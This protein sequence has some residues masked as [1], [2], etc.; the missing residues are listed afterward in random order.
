MQYC[1]R[2]KVQVLSPS[3]RCPLCQGSLEGEPEKEGQMFPD[4]TRGRSM[5][6]LFWKIFNFFCVAVVV[7]G[8][9][10]NLMIP[11]RI[12]WAGFLAAAVLC[13]WILTAVAIF[14]RKNLLKNALWEMALV[15]G[16]CIFWDVLT[17]YKGWSL[18]YGVPVAI[19]LVFPVLTTLV[20]IMR[21]PASDY[22]IYY[23]LACAAG[24]LQLLFWVVR[25]VE[26]K[27]LVILCGA[28]SAL[29][30]AGLMIFQGRNFWEELRKKTY[31]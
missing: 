4:M 28:V 2:C 10:V 25:L 31:M 19:L 20:K 3:R 30:L 27:V 9:A 8:V 12:F 5:M 15:S 6:S 14:K 7:I 22:M 16:F 21:L 18:E 17:G 24:I 1:K 29:I 23:I 13:M 11:S 26:M